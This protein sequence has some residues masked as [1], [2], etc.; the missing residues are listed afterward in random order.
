MKTVIFVKASFS[1]KIR[2]IS[3]RESPVNG[4]RGQA[5][6]IREVAEL[7]QKMLYYAQLNGFI[8]RLTKEKI[9]Q[10]YPQKYP[11]IP[12]NVFYLIGNC[13]THYWSTF[14]EIWPIA[15]LFNII[16][17]PVAAFFLII[18][19]LG[20][21]AVYGTVILEFL[22]VTIV[23]A[24]ALMKTHYSLLGYPIHF[25]E[26]WA[27]VKAR[28]F[29]FIGASLI[30]T[31]IALGGSLLVL[32]LYFASMPPNPFTFYSAVFTE[33]I[34]PLVIQIAFTIFGVYFFFAAPLALI[35]NS[36]VLESFKKSWQLVHHRWWHTFMLIFL[37]VIL[38]SIVQLILT[39]P[40]NVAFGI[41]SNFDVS[42]VSIFTLII[43][44]IVIGTLLFPA[45]IIL[46]L[47]ILHDLK[48]REV[49]IEN[50]Q[51]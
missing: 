5:A 48:L 15:L 23:G 21:P 26:T 25:S 6:G 34:L 24:M 12:L 1:N 38:I 33:I 50:Q 28:Y 46:I 36:Q 39:I 3:G 47:L 31:V 10:K 22:L 16:L 13:I 4:P 32:R 7:L 19:E 30:F 17:Q 43:G 37:V 27:K 35:Y 40:L 51:I 11:V 2:K 9:M 20:T 14:R 45:W 44:K 41:S 42:F 8:L 18:L 49:K 29:P